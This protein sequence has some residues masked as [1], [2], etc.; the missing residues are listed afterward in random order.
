MKDQTEHLATTRDIA[1]AAAVQHL[2]CAEHQ[3]STFQKLSKWLKGDEYAQLTSVLIPD[4][5]TNLTHTTW[6][7]VVEAQALHDVLT[8]G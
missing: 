5:P 6:T 8:K 4:D 2:L 1:K 7:S 3:A